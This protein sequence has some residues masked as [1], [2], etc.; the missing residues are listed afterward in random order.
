MDKTPIEIKLMQDIKFVIGLNEV[1]TKEI[2]KKNKIIKKQNEVITEYKKRFAE[3]ENKIAE[4]N[5]NN[6]LLLHQICETNK[7]LEIIYPLHHF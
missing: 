2:Q 4:L 5:N 1:K 7:Q 3:Y 6:T